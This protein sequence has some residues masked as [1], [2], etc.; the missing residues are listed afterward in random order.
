MHLPLKTICS[1]GRPCSGEGSSVWKLEFFKTF[2][3]TPCMTGKAEVVCLLSSSQA[4]VNVS[5]NKVMK[6]KELI[7]LNVTSKHYYIVFVQYRK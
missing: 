2:T 1:S 5:S 4:A 7:A 3:V 6:G